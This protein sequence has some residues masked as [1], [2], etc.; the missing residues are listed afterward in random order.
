MKKILFAAIVMVAFTGTSMAKT[1]EVKKVKKV[2]ATYKR[3]CGSYASHVAAA[4]EDGLDGGCLSNAQYNYNYYS[5]Y[6][7]CM[8]L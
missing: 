7:F 5:A 2:E 8:S 3:D 1:K 4:I 6:T